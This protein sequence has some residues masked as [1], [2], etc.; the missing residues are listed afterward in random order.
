WLVVGFE[1]AFVHAFNGDFDAA[2]D[3]LEELVDNGWRYYWWVLEPY[4]IF[5][6]IADHPRFRALQEKLEAGVREQREWFE[7][8]RN[9]P[10]I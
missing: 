9:E 5:E 1:P 10:L 6:P 8:R 7:A 4:P 3:V 2:L